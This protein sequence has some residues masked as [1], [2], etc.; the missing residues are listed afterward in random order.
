ML[1]VIFS[2]FIELLSAFISD[3]NAI[4]YLQIF[5]YESPRADYSRK[6]DT[7]S[8]TVKNLLCTMEL[9]NM[10]QSLHRIYSPLP[11]EITHERPV[12]L[13]LEQYLGRKGLNVSPGG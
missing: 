12:S 6:Q 8:E 7:T 1:F 5:L 3:W 2:Q 13:W 10:Q 4:M 11:P 9:E